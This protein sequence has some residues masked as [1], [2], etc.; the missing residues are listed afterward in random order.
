VE[1]DVLALVLCLLFVVSAILLIPDV[2]RAWSD[3][4]V[5]RLRRSAEANTPVHT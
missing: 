2:Q 3:R 5:A 4:S 1:N